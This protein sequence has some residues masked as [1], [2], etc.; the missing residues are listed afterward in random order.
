MVV[1]LA[2]RMTVVVQQASE[3]KGN[4]SP[5]RPQT[6]VFLLGI[7]DD[8]ADVPD[9][10]HVLVVVVRYVSRRITLQDLQ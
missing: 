8:E 2:C 7:P 1:V 3:H 10:L 6:D 4:G 9:P 5:V